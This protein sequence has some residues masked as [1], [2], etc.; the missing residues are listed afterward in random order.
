MQN[1]LFGSSLGGMH[2]VWFLCGWLSLTFKWELAVK[3][4][5]TKRRQ[6]QWEINKYRSL[7]EKMSQENEKVC[8][9]SPQSEWKSKFGAPD[10]YVMTKYI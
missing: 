10:E 4:G 7:R 9:Q 3:T 2:D 5:Q 6:H 1:R 8:F